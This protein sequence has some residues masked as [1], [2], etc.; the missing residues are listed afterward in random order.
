M[1]NA[2]QDSNRSH[3]HYQVSDSFG[4]Q[5][6]KSQNLLMLSPIPQDSEVGEINCV[7]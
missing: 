7:D 1:E 6:A 3:Y 2:Q 5:E 4:L